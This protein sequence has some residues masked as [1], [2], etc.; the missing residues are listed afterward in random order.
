METTEGAEGPENRCRG[1]GL[2]AEQVIICFASGGF[3]ISM[4]NVTLGNV[5]IFV[6]SISPMLTLDS[7]SV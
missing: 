5:A 1:C 3:V 4:I 2:S 6:A 7:L